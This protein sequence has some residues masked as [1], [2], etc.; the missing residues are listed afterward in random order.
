MSGLILP[1]SIPGQILRAIRERRIEAVAS[2]PLADEISRVLRLPKLQRYGITEEDIAQAL[3]LLAP[4]LPHVDVN[5]GL[6]DPK[7][8]AVV[9]AAVAGAAEAIVTGDAD[10]LDDDA[11]SR[12]LADRG[13]RV[14]TPTELVS[15]LER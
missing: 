11:L 8:V 12:W 5:V 6:R 15:V 3:A 1:D 13:I 14:L 2:W 4:F 7:D 9:E 10:L